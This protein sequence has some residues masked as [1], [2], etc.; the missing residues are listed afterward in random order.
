MSF[1][2]GGTA[3]D[4]IL[5][6]KVSQHKSAVIRRDSLYALLSH[7]AERVNAPQEWGQC[8]SVLAAEPVEAYRGSGSL[9]C[10]TVS[11]TSVVWQGR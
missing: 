7:C 5:C 10:C 3:R 9:S 6:Q 8:K 2:D 4:N 11:S 1:A